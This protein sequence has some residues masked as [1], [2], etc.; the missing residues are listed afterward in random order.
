MQ[1][2]VKRLRDLQAELEERTARW[3]MDKSGW[4]M[5]RATLATEHQK[6]V[7]LQLAKLE[8]QLKAKHHAEL[9]Q[10][11]Q[12]VL[13]ARKLQISTLPSADSSG[14]AASVGWW[15]YIALHW[16]CAYAIYLPSPHA[17]SPLSHT[18]S[19]MCL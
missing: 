13:V 14:G 11:Q 3:E 5:E 2:E 8:A 18:R 7:A 9:A 19:L 10:L 6:S 17:P 16:L 15:W 12:S 4:S 1:G